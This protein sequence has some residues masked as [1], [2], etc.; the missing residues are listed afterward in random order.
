MKYRLGID[1]GASSLGW[2]IV[3]LNEQLS[4]M[5]AVAGGARIF[6]DG[7]DP[8]SHTPLQVARRMTRGMSR[9]RDRLLQ[10]KHALLKT[11][12]K[13]GLMPVDEKDAK[14]LC[15]LN[16][17]RLRSLALEKKLEP[18]EIGRAIFHINQRRGFKSNR[19][20]DR[21]D[22]NEKSNV[23]SSISSLQKELAGRT[24]GQYLYVREKAK[25]GTRMRAETIKGK[26]QYEMYADRGM[27]IDEFKR[28]W[29]FQAQFHPELLTP[30]NKQRIYDNIFSQRPLKIPERGKCRFEPDQERAYA[31][32][33]ISQ[34]FRILQEVNNLEVVRMDS[35][36]LPLQNSDRSRLAAALMNP[37]SKMPDKSGIVAWKKIRKFLNLPESAKFNLESDTRKGLLCD[38]TALLL[39]DKSRFSDSWMLADGELR[40]QTIDLL[41]TSDDEGEIAKFLKSN[42]KI[43]DASI[44]NILNASMKLDAG[45]SSLSALA[46]SKIIPGL[47]KG[48][49]YDKVCM[50]AGYKHSGYGDGNFMDALPYYGAV[51]KGGVLGGKAEFDSEK[52]PEKHYGKIN[53]PTVHIALNQL[54]R[55]VNTLIGVYGKPEEIVVELAR[56]LPLGE[57]GLSEIK[58][59]QLKNKNDNEKIDEELEKLGVLK[60]R[61]NRIKFK[62]WE[63]L[64]EDPKKRM[65]PFCGRQI[66]LTELFSP[67]FEVEHLLPFSRTFDD[68][69]ANKVISCIRCNRLKRGRTPYEAFGPG[70]PDH[71][72][73]KWRE[74]ISRALEM[75]KSKQWRFDP[76]AMECFRGSESD[77]I[78]RMLNDTRYMARV[79]REYLAC[80]MPSHK[81]AAVTG[82]ATALLRGK[83]GLNSILAKDGEEAK[84]REDHRRHAIDAFVLACT[85]RGIMQKISLCAKMAEDAGLDKLIGDI[86]DPFDGYDRKKLEDIFA[87]MK[88]SHKPDRGNVARAIRENKTLGELHKQTAYGRI[89]GSDDDKQITIASRITLDSLKFKKDNIEQIGDD[90]IRKDLLRIYENLDAQKAGEKEWKAE[91]FQY[92]QKRGIKRVRIH[93]KNRET[94][95][96]IPVRDKNGKIYKYMDNSENYCMDIYMPS[97]SGKWQFEAVSMYAAHNNCAMPN[98]RKKDAK[99]KLVMRLFKNDI[100]AFDEN[101]QTHYRR[102]CVLTSHGQIKFADLNFAGILGNPPSKMPGALQKLNARKVY[103]DEIG[104][105]LDPGK[106]KYGGQ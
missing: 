12:K 51:L 23:K 69:R 97:D 88:A 67:S 45:T 95:K 40:R 89:G 38:T 47:R 16:P 75:H 49:M 80:L 70:S 34:E 91:L 22:D 104:R 71:D 59:E 78:A 58:K 99:A 94:Y 32:Y 33:P 63:D 105:I 41:M 66:P 3:R 102:I 55:V 31:A 52:E 72:G 90:K 56:D 48:L 36:E 62:L 5:E 24:L 83:W 43:S 2:F 57:K 101:G 87:N 19:R 30:E 10:R 29:D 26:N 93:L 37:F 18:H 98:W 85:D 8:Q 1:L 28:I 46:M 53:N 77:M 21:F 60:N 50:E 82:R 74:I 35:D 68:S 106:S 54:R 6:P 86:G 13:I 42:Y 27:Y 84:N 76:D 7:R 73:E 25:A 44:E 61:K 79:A 100:I 103:I 4:P 11:L 9:R 15:S 65:C 20:A 39:A 14:P 64:N 96:L 92:A 81:I 17:Y